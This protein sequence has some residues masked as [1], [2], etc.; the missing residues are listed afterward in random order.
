MKKA[1]LLLFG[2]GLVLGLAGCLLYAIVP[3]L[4]VRDFDRRS[5]SRL[6][7]RSEDI[8]GSF[9]SLLTGQERLLKKIGVAPPLSH[10]SELH[11][12]FKRLRLH[13][14]SE[15][16]AAFGNKGRLVLWSGNVVDISDHIGPEGLASLSKSRAPLIIKNKASIFLVSIAPIPSGGDIVLFKLLA[17][18]PKFTS[19]I[20]KETHELKAFGPGSESKIDYWSFRDD[21]SGFEKI[22]SRHHD[23]FIGQPR[24]RNEIQT[25]YFPL[26]GPDARILATVTLSSPSLVE[27]TTALREKIL[28]AVCLFFIVALTGLL[29]GSFASGNSSKKR[30]LPSLG[31]FLGAVIALR[32]LFLILAGLPRLRDLSVFSPSGAGFSSLGNLTGSPADIFLTTLGFAAVVG[33]LVFPSVSR[34]RILK[35]SVSKPLRLLVAAG[36]MISAFLLLR[37]F[38]NVVGRLVLHS[39]IPLLRFSPDAGFILLHA[40]L[41]L[42]LIAVLVVTIAILRLSVVSPGSLVAPL[43]MTGIL[44]GGSILFLKENS[45]FAAAISHA[46]LIVFLILAPRFPR[47]L[48]LRRG[49]VFLGSL[50]S[51]LVLWQSLE[52]ASS[53]KTRTLIQNSLVQVV[54]NQTRWGLFLVQ[55]SFPE[56][57]KSDRDILSFIKEPGSPDFAHTLWEKTLAAKFNWYSSLEILDN[58]GNILSRFSLNIPESYHDEASASPVTDWLISRRVIESLGRKFDCLVASRSLSENGVMVGRLRF[59]LS[60]EPETLPFLNSANPYFEI[61]RAAPLP[62][63]NSLDFGLVVFDF[64]GRPVYN[65]DRIKTGLGADILSRLT[66]PG[67]SFWTGFRDGGRTLDT[68]FFEQDG[69]VFGLFTPRK[70]PRRTAVDFLKLFFLGIAFIIPILIVFV[71]VSGKRSFRRVFWSFSNRVYAA[72]FAFMLIPILMFTFFTKDLFDR[73]FARRFIDEASVHAGFARSIMEDLSSVPDEARSGP[74]PPT[75]D[76]VLWTS[77][78]L[79]SDVNLYRDARLIS[80]SRREF[81]DA[82]LMPDLLDGDIHYDLRQEKAPYATRSLKIGGYSFQTL[83]IPFSDGKTPFVISMPLPYEKR[84][85]GLATSEL[86][87]FLIFLSMFFAILIFLFGRGIRAMIVVPIRKLLAGIQEVSLGNLDARVDHPARDEM[88]VLVDGFNAM[89]DDLKAQRQDLADMGRKVAWTEMAR[90][91][92]HEIKNPLTPIQLSAEHILKV[93]EDGHEDFEKTLKESVFYIISEVENLRNISRDFMEI[94]RDTDL[95]NEAFDF[96]DILEEILA[97]YKR[98]LSPG[99]VFTESFT[100]S[101]FVCSGDPGKM[102]IALRNVVANAV[103][104]VGDR[105]RIT[106]RLIREQNRLILRV[107]DTGPGMSRE[108]LEKIFDLYFSTKNSGTGLGLPITKKIVEDHG[109]TVSVSSEPGHGTEVILEIP[110]DR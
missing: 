15:G 12:L 65:P 77:A 97:P 43:V 89:I 30:R 99:I 39:N 72:F 16:I 33:R 59:L 101:D 88:K 35:P 93:Y 58:E 103:E 90:K 96:R 56:I 22:F 110:C 57:D 8:R 34:F 106:I 17:F 80:S 23:Q 7:D 85:A 76:L 66:S 86:L 107:S 108:V 64:S 13:T 63:L 70:S 44:F 73:V 54:R 4:A 69:R 95:L 75:D 3:F 19:A 67:A 71:L 83:A 79:S 37:L 5:L 92:A 105:G 78:T 91:V 50:L 74:T 31:I 51:V 41:F 46:A 45:A 28:L 98:L 9:S 20:V 61:L 81:F 49:V 84:E 62:S 10:L 25:V 100:G 60:L 47:P 94:S 6:K 42:G 52:E 24:R 14:E 104:A 109:G 26:R 87:E 102:K 68:Y 82:G 2:L 40:G 36:A 27:M 53:L 55:Q 48:R 29:L 32:F 38:H 11:S 18:I 1:H 21:V